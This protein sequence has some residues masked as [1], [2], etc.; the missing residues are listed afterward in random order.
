MSRILQYTVYD[1]QLT[2]GCLL[3]AIMWCLFYNLPQNKKDCRGPNRKNLTVY[4]HLGH[5]GN[6]SM[7]YFVN[8]RQT[9]IVLSIDIYL[10]IGIERRGE[11]GRSI[12]SSVFTSGTPW[13]SGGSNIAT[14]AEPF[15]AGAP[16]CLSKLSP[17][18][19]DEVLVDIF[20][21]VWWLCRRLFIV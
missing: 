7:W 13:I 9:I 21:Y 16:S 1:M 19:F 14:A 17:E 8:Y 5:T 2:L 11:S 12:D 10:S 18:Q 15:P 6:C 20:Q 4:T 3:K